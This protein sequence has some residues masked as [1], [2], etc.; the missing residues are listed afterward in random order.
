MKKELKPLYKAI[1]KM[2]KDKVSTKYLLDSVVVAVMK[3]LS[4]DIFENEKQR[5]AGLQMY[6]DNFLDN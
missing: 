1:L 6:I 2:S 3:Y 4:Y 5:K